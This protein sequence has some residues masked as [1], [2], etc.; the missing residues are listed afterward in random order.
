MFKG[1]PSGFVVKFIE[2]SIAKD[3]AKAKQ[4]TQTMCNMYKQASKKDKGQIRSK[5]DELY[6]MASSNKCP[7]TVK[8]LDNLKTEL[9]IK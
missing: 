6:R 4:L 5:I 8:F 2:G 1:M 3:P 9:G 7:N